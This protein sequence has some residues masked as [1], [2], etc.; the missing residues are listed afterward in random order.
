MDS[1]QSLAPFFFQLAVKPGKKNE[2]EQPVRGALATLII[3]AASGE[4]AREL[5]GRHLAANKWEITEIK[6]IQILSAQ[7]LKKLSGELL[8]TLKQAQNLGIGCLI[9]TW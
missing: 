3:Y 4:K 8:Q 2:L 9:D 7:D 5:M 6:R 1:N